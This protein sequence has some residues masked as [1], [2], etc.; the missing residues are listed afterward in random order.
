MPATLLDALPSA[1][2]R[3]Q[4]T[5]FC[6]QDVVSALRP[7]E[8]NRVFWVAD[9]DHPEQPPWLIASS[10]AQALEWI[11]QHETKRRVLA[12]VRK[13]RKRPRA[14]GDDG[15]G[16]GEEEEEEEEEGSGADSAPSGKRRKT[17]AG[18]GGTRQAMLEQQRET[19]AFYRQCF[20]NS[21]EA[22]DM[23]RE[24]AL[25]SNEHHA[26]LRFVGKQPEAQQAGDRLIADLV[27]RATAVGNTEAVE[28]VQVMM[29]YWRAS[30]APGRH[31]GPV[32]ASQPTSTPTTDV[33]HNT[34]HAQRF[35]LYYQRAV[36]AESLS[37]LTNVHRR[38]YAARA[39]EEYDRCLAREAD[40]NADPPLSAHQRNRIKLRLFQTIHPAAELAVPAAGNSEWETFQRML[41]HGN[42]WLALEKDFTCGIFALLPKSRISNTYLERKLSDAFYA[43]WRRTLRNCSPLAVRMA[44]TLAP[45]VQQMACNES[46]P[47]WRLR[48]EELTGPLRV[49]DTPTDWLAELFER[50]DSSSPRI[51]E[52][53][54]EEEG[55]PPQRPSKRHYQRV[56]YVSDSEAVEEEENLLEQEAGSEEEEHEHE[57]EAQ[58]QS[59]D[60]YEEVGDADVFATLEDPI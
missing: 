26:W 52:V 50:A 55:S 16:S 28:D 13:V 27:C 2:A 18:G 42:R 15:E 54:G 35:R 6:G 47:V 7:L 17:A 12:F 30:H 57:Q 11:C 48:L 5:E 23:E 46:P 25:F 40:P 33:T 14:A 37:V 9:H 58:N 59:E 41:K 36:H 20:H 8:R 56:E 4:L 21:Q 45:L 22:A 32:L 31:A 29:R 44:E 34:T 3:A 43:L 19:L 49:A 10:P 53:A 38:Y 60:E 51:Y 1:S 24:S 39:R